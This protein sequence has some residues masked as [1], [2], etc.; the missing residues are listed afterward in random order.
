VYLKKDGCGIRNPLN[1][2][3]LSLLLDGS[4]IEEISLSTVTGSEDFDATHQE[5]L[6]FILDGE[7]IN[8]ISLNTFI[9]SDDQ[10]SSESNCYNN[11]FDE[12]NHD[13]MTNLGQRK[14]KS[15]NSV[16]K[17]KIEPKMKEIKEKEP[18]EKQINIPIIGKVN[19]DFHKKERGEFSSLLSTQST[20]IR[21]SVSPRSVDILTPLSPT[22]KSPLTTPSISPRSP[23]SQ[24]V[25][26]TEDKS[27]YNKKIGIEFILYK[28]LN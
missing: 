16:K 1:I 24:Q 28:S 2:N 26:F 13:E 4:Q 7:N 10:S 22:A 18:K 21:S 11:K 6:S 17:D 3:D 27:N 9:V 19:L 12:I 23:K 25:L 14:I 20:P 8:N 15:F 5:D